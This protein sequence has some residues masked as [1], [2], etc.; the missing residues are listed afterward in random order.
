MA[1]VSSLTIAAWNARFLLESQR[2]NW[3]ERRTTLVARELARYKVDISVL[4]ETRFSEQGQ[5]EEV[6]TGTDEVTSKF[7]Q[8]LHVLGAP[9]PKAD[10]L[11]VL[12]DFNTHVGTDHAV[13][14][15]FQRS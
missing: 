11:V 14:R 10:K 9:V 12:G 8:G 5:L 6:V 3:S 4:S 13:S 7:H 2:S 15:W 1:R